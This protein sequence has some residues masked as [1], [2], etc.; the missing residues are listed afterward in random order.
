MTTVVNLSKYRSQHSLDASH[1]DWMYI[2]RGSKQF[3][4]ERSPLA[5]PFKLGG[6]KRGATL[7]AYKRYLWKQIRQGN[8]DIIA[9]LLQVKPT[10][11]LVCHCEQPGPCH[12]HVV[13][14]A[15]QWVHENM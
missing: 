9:A 11:A 12:G 2:G 10:T 15:A 13:M 6:R 3:G 5:N 1:R 14:A 8:R 4:L 7:P